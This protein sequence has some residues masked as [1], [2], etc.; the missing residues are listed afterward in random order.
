M[1]GIDLTHE[2]PKYSFLVLFACLVTTLL[3]G[4][5]MFQSTWGGLLVEI[6]MSCT[7]AASV[8]ALSGRRR[9]LYLSAAVAV[10][11]LALNW[12]TVFQYSC[13]VRVIDEVLS[14]CFYGLVIYIMALRVF[15]THKVDL[16]VIVGAICIYL[17]GAIMFS[18]VFSLI[19]VVTPG[20]F[21]AD[22]TLP[23]PSCEYEYQKILAGNLL[24]FSLVTL[25][26]LG[27]GDITPLAPIAKAIASMEAVTGQFYIA[28]L[29]ARLVGLYIRQEEDEHVEA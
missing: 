24:Y 4:A 27:Y 17:I 9:P 12:I 10:I 11:V 7:L 22:F 23:N 21:D 16:N 3:A 14:L 20:S 2:P 29:V 15:S 19:E 26:T 6:L 8:F 1:K 5:V 28:I 25:S 18:A 13:T